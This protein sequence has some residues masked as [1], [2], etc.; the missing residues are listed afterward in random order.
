MDQQRGCRRC[1]FYAGAA[2]IELHPP[3][4][5][6]RA[7]LAAD[8]PFI[9]GRA[10]S[11]GSDSPLRAVCGQPPIR[12]GEA[13][14]LRPTGTLVVRRGDARCACAQRQST[15]SFVE[16][17]SNARSYTSVSAVPTPDPGTLA[18]RGS[19][20]RD[21]EMSDRENL[22]WRA[23]AAQRAGAQEGE[24]AEALRPG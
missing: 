14:D 13:S 2:Q 10:A 8:G 11:D 9:W 22:Q 20:R 19:M 16:H 4:T 23:G 15:H 5:A 7:N 18:R 17:Q 24:S 6:I 1:T 3:S 12:R 21:R